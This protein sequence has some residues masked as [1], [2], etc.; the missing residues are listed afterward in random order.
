M[1]RRIG[2]IYQQ[3][4]LVPSLSALK[5]TL[6]GSLG[7]WSLAKTLRSIVRPMKSDLERALQALEIV[8][9]ADQRHARADEL[10]GG[11]QQRVA[12]ARMLMQE[13]DVILADEPIASLDPALADGIL[14]LLARLAADGKRTLLISLH[15]AELAMQYFPRVLALKAG[16]VA[17]D[18]AAPGVSRD[19]LSHLYS[20][21][22]T[23]KA[24]HGSYFQREPGCLR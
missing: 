16:C 13:P 18:G 2:T 15:R 14:S 17:F 3:H 20:D 12:I 8:G 23:H 10:S 19:L 9:L 21:R 5:N 11:Q 1:R 4:N 24:Q 7:Q 22:D 6:C